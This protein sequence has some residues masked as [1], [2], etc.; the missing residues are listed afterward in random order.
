VLD[1]IQRQIDLAPG[2]SGKQAQFHDD[3][4]SCREGQ[5][6]ASGAPRRKHEGRESSGNGD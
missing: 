5:D 6:Y 4:S 3:V 1:R 2:V